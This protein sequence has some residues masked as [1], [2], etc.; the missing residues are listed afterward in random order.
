MASLPICFSH[1]ARTVAVLRG[2]ER[3]GAAPGQTQ[4]A[5]ALQPETEAWQTVLTLSLSTALRHLR[6]AGPGL[7]GN[8]EPTS[9]VQH[10][11]GLR[12]A[13]LETAGSVETLSTGT[14]GRAQADTLVIILALK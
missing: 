4:G 12:T 13:T 8:T 1:P 3:A 14:C 6:P 9:G 5:A 2:A 7:G 11:A 10:G